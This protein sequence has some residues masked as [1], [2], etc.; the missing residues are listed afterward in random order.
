MTLVS[1]LMTLEVHLVWHVLLD[2]V[3]GDFFLGLFPIIVT[4]PRS[5]IIMVSDVLSR[6]TERAMNRTQY[7]LSAY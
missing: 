3:F 4:P 2:G 7:H 6:N 5:V 1:F